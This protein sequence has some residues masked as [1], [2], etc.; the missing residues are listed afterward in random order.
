[1]KPVLF[2]NRSRK[3]LFDIRIHTESVWSRKQAVRYLNLLLDE[4]FS[5]PGREDIVSYPEYKD[6]HYSHC[7][8]HFVFFRSTACDIRIVRILHER[9]SFAR[10]LGGQ[11]CR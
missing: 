11:E 7:G 10:H 3:D 2:S 8:Q 6:Y 5:I 9:M 4:C 1:M